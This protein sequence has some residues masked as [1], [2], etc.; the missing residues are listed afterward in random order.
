MV[1][2]LAAPFFQTRLQGLTQATIGDMIGWEE[3]T[4]KQYGALLKSI[5]TQVL[6]LAKKHQKGRVTEKVTNVTFD[7]TELKP[8]FQGKYHFEGYLSAKWGIA[9]GYP[10]QRT[11]HKKTESY[12]SPKTDSLKACG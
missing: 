1:N 4:I 9:K 8:Y 6:E 10:T 5:V 3:S 2:H 12:D 11:S 7:F